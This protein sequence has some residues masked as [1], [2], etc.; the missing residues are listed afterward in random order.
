[1]IKN[2]ILIWWPT[3]DLLLFSSEA[4]VPRTFGV[5]SLWFKEMCCISSFKQEGS[6][7]NSTPA[8]RVVT[9]YAVIPTATVWICL[10]VS[11]SSIVQNQTN[12]REF[13]ESTQM[14]SSRAYFTVGAQ[15]NVTI[16]VSYRNTEECTRTYEHVLNTLLLL[17]CCCLFFL[18]SISIIWYHSLLASVPTSTLITL[19]FFSVLF[20]QNAHFMPFSFSLRQLISPQFILRVIVLIC[21]L[22]AGSWICLTPSWVEKLSRREHNLAVYKLCWGVTGSNVQFRQN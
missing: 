11:N 10:S 18:F 9:Q 17:W 2:V 7:T 15:K 3:T 14:N 8:L 19:L 22:Q 5:S 1:M 20:L 6:C 13:F 16:M 21:F 4:P 12:S